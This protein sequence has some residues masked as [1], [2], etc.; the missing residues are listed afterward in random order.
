MILWRNMENY[1]WIMPITSSYLEQLLPMFSQAKQLSTEPAAELGKLHFTDKLWLTTLDVEGKKI[2]IC[3][4]PN[5][6][7]NLIL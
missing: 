4:W 1:P 6:F 2:I 7:K 3:S 5:H